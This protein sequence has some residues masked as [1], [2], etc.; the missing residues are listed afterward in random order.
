MKTDFRE[1]LTTHVS[2][3]WIDVCLEALKTSMST[4]GG[5]DE[6]HI[7]R[8]M[9]NARRIWDKESSHSD[10]EVIAAA[11]LMHDSVNLPKD[12]PER[13]FASTRSAELARSVLAPFFEAQRLECLASAI[14]EHSFSSG[15]TPTSLEAKIVCD[16]DRLEAIGAIGIA[17]TFYVSGALDR[18]IAHLA[19]PFARKRALDETNYGV[20]HF[21][22][23]LL[24]VADLM[25]TKT[26]QAIARERHE[27]LVRFL[28]ELSDELGASSDELDLKLEGMT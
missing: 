9:Q 15:L 28:H 20:D 17:R 16:A 25:H 22:E 23:K 8:V 10:W 1:A 4:D 24:K 19:D 14:R 2:Y 18:G 27:R 7:F 11:V 21:F 12:H 5:H 13:S 6:A 3:P 26:G